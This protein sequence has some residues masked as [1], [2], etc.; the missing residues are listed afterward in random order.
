MKKTPIKQATAKLQLCIV[1]AQTA[2]YPRKV[3]P[4]RTGAYKLD[5]N[6]TTRD[7]LL[8]YGNKEACEGRDV[9]D[10]NIKK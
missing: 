10:F 7:L 4:T 8:K 9:C 3:E 2:K 1:C 6:M 5:D